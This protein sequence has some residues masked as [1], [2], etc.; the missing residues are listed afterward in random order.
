M[1]SG[2]MLASAPGDPSRVLNGPALPRGGW[3]LKKR[4][5]APPESRRSGGAGATGLFIQ[6]CYKYHSYKKI[7]KETL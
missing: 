5:P 3:N 4:G 6:R 2:R 1:T 7:C